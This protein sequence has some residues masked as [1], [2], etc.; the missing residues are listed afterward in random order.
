MTKLSQSQFRSYLIIALFLACL[1]YLTNITTDSLIATYF[2]NRLVVQDLLIS[3]T[4]FISWTQY[5][6]DTLALISPLLALTFIIRVRR[7]DLPFA[8]AVIS[9]GE[10]IR[11]ILI[12]ATP[13]GASFTDS[14]QY[15]FITHAQN[16]QFPSGHTIMVA[17]CYA[18]I[19][20]QEA[21]TLKLILLLSMLGEMAALIFSRGH[22]TIDI[23]GG[24]LITYFVFNELRRRK[25]LV[26]KPSISHV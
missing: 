5:L 15:G 1:A 14:M 17:S 9:I 20:R 8:I 7:W 3:L 26:L 23:V 19:Q 13:L 25:F 21:P 18:L 24:L 6:A 4:P 10:L 12:I 22:Y 11:G 2:P 16:G